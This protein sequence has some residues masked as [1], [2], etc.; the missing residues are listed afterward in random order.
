MENPH[1]FNL[2]KERKGINKKKMGLFAEHQLEC[3]Y[4]QF[5]HCKNLHFYTHK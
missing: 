4:L 5:Q 2:S 1:N 3:K